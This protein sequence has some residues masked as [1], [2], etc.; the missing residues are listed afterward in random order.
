MSRLLGP[1]KVVVAALVAVVACVAMGVLPPGAVRSA[2]SGPPGGKS[3]VPL[4]LLPVSVPFKTLAAVPA[5]GV[6]SNITYTMTSSAPFCVQGLRM[7][8]N[9]SVATGP[10]DAGDLT[11]ALSR[12]DGAGLS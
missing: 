1:S 3:V 5:G 4:Q 10:G 8:P 12:I 7:D 9:T 2:H 11:I 6:P